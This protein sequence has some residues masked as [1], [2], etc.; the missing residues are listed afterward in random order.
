MKKKRI[1]KL[2]GYLFWF[3]AI[4]IIVLSVIPYQNKLTETTRE[5]S[6]RFDYLEHLIIFFLLSILFVFW[7][8]KNLKIFNLLFLIYLISGLLFAS[9]MEIVQLYIPNRTFNLID[10]AYN[11]AGIIMGLFISFIF[12]RKKQIKNIFF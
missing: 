7:K 9:F 8:R 10:M 2:T 5:G 1:F 6:I 4:L 11:S 12:L 3:W